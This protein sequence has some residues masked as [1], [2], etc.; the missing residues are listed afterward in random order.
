MLTVAVVSGGAPDE[1]DGQ[2][3]E[4]EQSRA[5]RP[6]GISGLC[7]ADSEQR[8]TLNEMIEIKIK[9]LEEAARKLRDIGQRAREL[10]GAHEA[11]MKEIFPVE[12]MS[13][14]TDFSSFDG[15]LNASGFK[16]ETL[17]DFA[18]IPDDQ[19]DA[20]VSARTR[21]KNWMEMR[22]AGIRGYVAGKLRV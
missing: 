1:D 7:P 16:I 9:G 15:M 22:E 18:A 17:K 5:R 19:W 13:K 4:S 21:F 10:E 20:F 12:F 11:P 2:R 8:Y 14:Y 6:P 3:S